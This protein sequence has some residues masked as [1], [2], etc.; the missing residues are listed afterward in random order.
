MKVKNFALFEAKTKTTIPKGVRQVTYLEIVNDI[1][2]GMT[3]SQ[4]GL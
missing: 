4:K 3:M 2:R 1:I